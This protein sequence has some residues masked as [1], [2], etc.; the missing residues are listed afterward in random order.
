MAGED[1]VYTDWLRRFVACQ[2]PLAHGCTGVEIHHPTHLRI[3]GD[4]KRRA[5]DHTAVRLCVTSH[6]GGLHGLAGNGGFQG[7]TGDGIRAFCDLKR[8]ENRRRYL[9]LAEQASPGAMAEGGI[10][11]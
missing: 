2:A 8:E 11:F 5:H 3:T 4:D 1:R 10:P 6:V 7:F 9:A